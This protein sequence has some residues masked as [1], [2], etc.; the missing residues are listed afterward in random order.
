MGNALKFADGL[1]ELFAFLNV[2]K[3]FLEDP[4]GRDPVDGHTRNSV[5]IVGLDR[6]FERIGAGDEFVLDG[7]ASIVEEQ[8][9][10]RAAGHVDVRISNSEPGCVAVHEQRSDIVA[11]QSDISDKCVGSI[12]LG[13]PGLPPI[14]HV[15]VAVSLGGR[16]HVGDIAAMFGFAHRDGDKR[17]AL[18]DW[19]EILFF[20]FFGAEFRDDLYVSDIRL[21]NECC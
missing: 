7:N 8:L 1:V 21:P 20:E 12:R 2:L 4:L 6:P 10:L 16:V 19:R 3:G 17:F 9:A 5:N 15:L 18:T 11:R 14:Q 13:D